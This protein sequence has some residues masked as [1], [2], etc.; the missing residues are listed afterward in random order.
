[1]L[2]Q[3]PRRERQVAAGDEASGLTVV[4][5]PKEM[6]AAFEEQAKAIRPKLEPSST[7]TISAKGREAVAEFRAKK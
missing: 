3:I 5:S 6:I 4:E 7:A 2:K 1:V